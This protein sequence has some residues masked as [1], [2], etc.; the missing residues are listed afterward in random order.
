[1]INQG[2]EISEYS[3]TSVNFTPIIGSMGRAAKLR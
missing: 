1:M 3:M 2:C